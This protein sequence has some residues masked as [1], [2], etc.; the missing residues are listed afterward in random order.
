VI[1]GLAAS[2]LALVGFGANS[3]LDGAASAVLVWRFRHERGGAADP[4]AVERRAAAGVGAAM[5]AVALY[6]G[7]SAVN[8]LAS[9]SEPEG[10]GVGVALTAASVLVLPVLAR[11]K[12]RLA[13][14][15]QS[16]ALRGDGVL[17]LAGAVLAA[18]TLVSLVLE[19]AFDWWWA[20]ATAALAISAALAIEGVR[21]V[22]SARSAPG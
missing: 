16:P 20:D 12:L 4:D 7:V 17:S 8:A 1:A 10:S 22:A 15:L 6:L 18:A 14:P 3:T 19:A 2:S 9:H 13:A 11:A 21:V 5:V